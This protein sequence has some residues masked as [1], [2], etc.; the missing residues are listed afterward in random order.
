MFTAAHG[1]TLQHTAHTAPHCNT[2]QHI[3]TLQQ[4]VALEDAH[5]TDHLNPNT[6]SKTN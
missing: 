3:V 6:N 2:L 5:Y 4:V 1:N